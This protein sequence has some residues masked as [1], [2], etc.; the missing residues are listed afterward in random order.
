MKAKMQL[1]GQIYDTLVAAY[2]TDATA[3]DIDH[4]NDAMDC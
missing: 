3:Y 2:D 4:V 1:K